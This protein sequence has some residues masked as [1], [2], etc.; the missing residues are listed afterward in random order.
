MTAI[1]HII[2]G[3]ISIGI[4]LF[5][6][7]ITR[8][9]RNDLAK[10]NLVKLDEQ[11]WEH[12]SSLMSSRLQRMNDF[13]LSQQ[14][15]ISNAWD[16]FYKEMGITSRLEKII[17]EWILRFPMNPSIEDLYNE[18]FSKYNLNFTFNQQEIDAFYDRTNAIIQFINKIRNGKVISN[19]EWNDFHRSMADHVATVFQRD[20]ITL[21]D[22]LPLKVAQNL[23][24]VARLTHPPENDFRKYIEQYINQPI[25][26]ENEWDIWL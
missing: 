7:F 15:Y 10:S 20:F 21:I 9:S 17:H 12:V 14:S 5:I 26:L 16:A 6:Y 2:T 18:L 11:L 3:L 1:D 4:A 24:E 8:K 22:N 13:L 19:H 25:S 23:Y